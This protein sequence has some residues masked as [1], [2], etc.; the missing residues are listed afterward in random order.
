MNNTSKI[1]LLVNFSYYFCFFVINRYNL[2]RSYNYCGRKLDP[3]RQN[4]LIF[5]KTLIALIFKHKIVFFLLYIISSTTCT[6]YA[7]LIHITP[8]YLHRMGLSLSKEI[9][10]TFTNKFP[11]K[12]LL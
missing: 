9:K 1:K 7:N 3:L 6:N 11:F 2:V 4:I 12:I 5:T 8:A 10:F